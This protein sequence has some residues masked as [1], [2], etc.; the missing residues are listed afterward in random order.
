MIHTKTWTCWCPECGLVF[1]DRTW[2]CPNC[3][4]GTELRH[5]TESRFGAAE[6]AWLVIAGVFFGGL[7]IV[8]ILSNTN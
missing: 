4:R 1:E 6:I 2:P 3:G 8:G 7:L 5:S